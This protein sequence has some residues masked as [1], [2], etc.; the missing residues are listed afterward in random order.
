ML[1]TISSVYF[2]RVFS[3]MFYES[4]IQ[5]RF[6]SVDQLEQESAER[7]EQEEQTPTTG[8]HLTDV[9]KK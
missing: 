3:N 6:I 9:S 8:I 1:N 4:K 7:V 5:N 2:V